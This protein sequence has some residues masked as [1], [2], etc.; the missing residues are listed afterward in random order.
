MIS[1]LRLFNGV[2]IKEKRALIPSKEEIDYFNKESIKKGYIVD[3]KIYNSY[4]IN[5]ITLLLRTIE[6]YIIT[7]Y[8]NWNNSF[9]KSWS[10][11][12]KRSDFRLKIEQILHYITTYGFEAMGIKSSFVYIPR[13]EVELPELEKDISFLFIKALTVEETEKKLNELIQSGIAMSEQTQIDILNIYNQVGFDA[14]IIEK[15]RNKELKSKLY[16]EYD[17]IPKNATE[18]LRYVITESTGNSLVI[19]DPSTISAI[20]ECDN[21]YKVVSS[22]M[23]YKDSY[24]LIPLSK[25]F[26]RYKPLFLAFKSY[27]ELKPIINRIRKLAVKY[28]KP[29]HPDL[30]NDITDKLNNQKPI[31]YSAFYKALNKVNAFRKIRLLY[32]LQNMVDQNKEIVY[33]IRNGKSYATNRKLTFNIDELRYVKNRIYTCIIE[34]LKKII[35]KKLFYIPNN[36]NYALP[37]TEKQFIG[38]IPSGSSVNT[39]KD[40]VI[41]IHWYNQHTR[42]VDLDLSLIDISGAKYGWDAQYR[43]GTR[44]VLFSG[45]ITDAP[46][47]NGASEFYYFKGI[48][49]GSYLINLNFYNASDFNDKEIPFHIV[50]GQSNNYNI[51]SNFILDPNGILLQAPSSMDKKQKVLGLVLIENGKGTFYFSESKV[52]GGRTSKGTDISLIHQR[53]LLNTLK[54]SI[55]FKQVLKDA[56]AKFTNDVKECD[57]DFSSETITKDSILSL[58]YGR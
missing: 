39:N 24:S 5:D 36:I 13:G 37:A 11:L 17:L 1:T 58:F 42:R 22:F 12:E 49:D 16:K 50:I 53:F 25:F 19:K 48:Q 3:P 14:S 7:S 52:G 43:N 47:P 35:D 20:K 46:I 2:I 31:D 30:L 51:N 55:N 44:T 33:K 57:Y 54:N 38:N 27:S 23:K 15:C 9:Y 40:M 32:A 29:M 21:A 28:H 4:S 8:E 18:F 34:D 6:K 10:I 45:D 56:G 41:G 26:Y